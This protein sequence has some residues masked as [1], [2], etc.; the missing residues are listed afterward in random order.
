MA[1]RAVIF[2]LWGTLVPFDTE[3]WQPVLT[4]IAEVLEVATSA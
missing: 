1:L 4:S 3:C 2:D